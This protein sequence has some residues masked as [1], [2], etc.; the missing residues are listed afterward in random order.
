[1]VPGDYAA[2]CEPINGCDSI[3]ESISDLDAASLLKRKNKPKAQIVV[4]VVSCGHAPVCRPHDLG[5]MVQTAA[6]NHAVRAG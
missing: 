3:L 2:E 5:Q 1:M 4:A 6:A